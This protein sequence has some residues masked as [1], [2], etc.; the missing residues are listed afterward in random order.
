M[1]NSIKNITLC[2]MVGVLALSGCGVIKNLDDIKNDTAEMKGQMKVT[3]DSVDHTNHLAQATYFDLRKK[4]SS[5]KR[6]EALNQMAKSEG[7]NAKLLYGSH[8]IA[9]FE[10]QS[11]KPDLQ[12]DHERL[13]SNK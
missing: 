8:Y 12:D 3:N 5:S 6:V 10:Y 4:D 7:I 2:L 11:F 13:Q 1:R 9:A